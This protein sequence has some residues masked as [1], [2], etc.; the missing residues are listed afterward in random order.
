[1]ES[2]IRIVKIIS[3]EHD[4]HN[5]K[6][7]YPLQSHDAKLLNNQR[8]KTKTPERKDKLNSWLHCIAEVMT[9]YIPEAH[10][11]KQFPNL[12]HK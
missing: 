8:F 10:L 3:Y 12:T 5:N 7:I 1:M 6:V 2:Q 11:E 9:M 4:I